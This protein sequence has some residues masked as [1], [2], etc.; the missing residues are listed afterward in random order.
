MKKPDGLAAVQWIYEI[1]IQIV[2]F[3]L[4][5]MLAAF[6]K[7][8][9]FFKSESRENRLQDAAIRKLSFWFVLE[10]SG[11]SLKSELF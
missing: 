9:N 11:C 1:E 4:E 6:N 3:V 7:N 2:S 5:S 8:N 10:K